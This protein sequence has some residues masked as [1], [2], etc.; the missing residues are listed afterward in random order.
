MSA[1][2]TLPLVIMTSEDTDAKTREL[3]EK[4]GRYGMEEGQIIIVMQDK[5]RHEKSR[6]ETP[7]KRASSFNIFWF[8]HV[9]TQSMVVKITTSLV[10]V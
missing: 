3:V 4:E 8:V 7:P 2:L 9:Q 10:V 6:W 1:D 5:A